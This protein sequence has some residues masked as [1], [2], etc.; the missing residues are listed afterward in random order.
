MTIE[1]VE[2]ETRGLPELIRMLFLFSS[3]LQGRDG[4]QSVRAFIWRKTFLGTLTRLLAG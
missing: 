2:V 3:I 1:Q 4:N